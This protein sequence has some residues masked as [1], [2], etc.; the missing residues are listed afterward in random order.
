[1]SE[2]N[3]VETSQREDGIWQS[4]HIPSGKKTEGPTQEE[5]MQSM[6]NLLGMNESNSF[7][8]PLT[9]DRFE[10]TDKEIAVFLEGE[11]SEM[12]ALHSGFAR[13]EGMEQGIAYIKLGGGCSGCPSSTLTLVQGVKEQLQEKFG[14]ENIIDVAPSL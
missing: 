2:L 7:T 12:L 8:E 13:L 11:I 9:S 3:S 4:Y 10:G 14:E 1:M 5:A 6:R